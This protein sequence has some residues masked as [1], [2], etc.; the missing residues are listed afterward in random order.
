MENLEGQSSPTQLLSTWARLMTT[1][2][3]STTKRQSE[4]APCD[5]ITAPIFVENSQEQLHQNHYHLINNAEKSLSAVELLLFSDAYMIIPENVK[6]SKYRL[7]ELKSAYA[8]LDIPTYSFQQ[9]LKAFL[10][11]CAIQPLSHS[12]IKSLLLLQYEGIV[13]HTISTM[14]HHPLH[15]IIQRVLHLKSSDATAVSLK[16][17]QTE[18]VTGLHSVL[19]WMLTMKAIDSITPSLTDMD[20]IAM[21]ETN[22]EELPLNYQTRTTLHE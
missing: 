9:Q 11:F 3:T 10:I 21:E 5:D 7:D 18:L 20:I 14:F 2:N 12:E 17:G 4:S 15:K 13:A 19:R 22:P 8:S 6:Q 1:P 16:L